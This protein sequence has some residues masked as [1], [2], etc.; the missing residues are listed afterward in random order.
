MTDEPYANIRKVK[1]PVIVKKQPEENQ[2]VAP[3]S[4][5]T[6]TLNIEKKEQINQLIQRVRSDKDSAIKA[7]KSTD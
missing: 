6:P 4:D 2:N 3:N 7:A 1:Q 5:I